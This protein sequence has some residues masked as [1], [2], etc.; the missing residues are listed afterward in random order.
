MVLELF[1]ILESL[2]LGK[3][4][5]K[6]I[7]HVSVAQLAYEISL[8]PSKIEFFNFHDFVS[9][10]TYFFHLIFVWKKYFFWCFVL[11]NYIFKGHHYSWPPYLAGSP[12][13]RLLLLDP[14]C[15]CSCLTGC[16]AGAGR[17]STPCRGSYHLWTSLGKVLKCTMCMYMILTYWL[18]RHTTR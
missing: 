9:F 3:I 15:C 11:N 5:S 17:R 2:L 1:N 16:T 10:F 13:P 6:K 12:H 18:Q 14:R 4:L 7:K 8:K